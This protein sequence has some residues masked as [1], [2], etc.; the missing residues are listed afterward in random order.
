MLLKLA[1]IDWELLLALC[2]TVK[3]GFEVFSRKS[4]IPRKLTQTKGKLN[5]LLAISTQNGSRNP[6][7]AS[8]GSK[9]GQK[10]TERARKVKNRVLPL[11][12]RLPLPKMVPK[13]TFSTKWEAEILGKFSSYSLPLPPQ[14][15]VCEKRIFI[16][17][18]LHS[19][20]TE[21]TPNPLTMWDLQGNGPYSYEKTAEK[22]NLPIS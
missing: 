16:I 14:T 10:V 20:H 2:K 22:R 18:F 1:R 5:F 4:A 6:N 8:P 19:N 9:W 21:Q 15:Q 3:W 17:R 12:L 11:F 7:L 13:T